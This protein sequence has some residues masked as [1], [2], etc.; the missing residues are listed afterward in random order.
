V[1]VAFNK[2]AQPGGTILS[3]GAVADEPEF[4][5]L[6]R[7]V[8]SWDEIPSPMA[9][10]FETTRTDQP[11]RGKEYG[12]GDDD[13]GKL[14]CTLGQD[15]TVL[16]TLMGMRKQMKAWQIQFSS[17]ATITFNGMILGIKPS[18]KDK[19][20]NTWQMTIQPSGTPAYAAPSGAAKKGGGA[21][22]ASLSA[23]PKAEVPP[24]LTPPAAAAGTSDA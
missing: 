11:D 10:V 19:D 18:V 20:E 15:D 7:I 6:G 1:T 4:T 23:T 21:N 12:V 14:V 8:K 3:Y 22:A 16:A 5:P 2:Y 9:D 24:A 17:T 13:P